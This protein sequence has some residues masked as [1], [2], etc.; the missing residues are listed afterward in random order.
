MNRNLIFSLAL[1]FIT[2]S[3]FSCS[4]EY[5]LDTG[6]F[7]TAKG[8]LHDLSGNC[9]TATILGN[10]YTGVKVTDSNYVQVQVNVTSA[11][12]Y[13][14]ASD[15]ANGFS[16]TNAGTFTTT[17]LQ[18]IKLKAAGTPNLNQN[19]DFI[20]SFDSTI[21]SFTVLVQDST[22]IPGGGGATAS[23]T[24]WQF[25]EGPKYFHGP[26]DTAF[27]FD[28]IVSG[29]KYTTVQVQGG[30]AA[31]RDS[32]LLLAVTF[33]NGVITPGTYPTTS[34]SVFKFFGSSDPT[35][36]LYSATFLTTTVATTVQV[37]AYNSTTRVIQGTF[38]GTAK[39][40]SG[41]SA[42]ITGGK[43]AAKLN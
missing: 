32:V 27:T 37:T 22:G 11:G 10:Y 33:P 21:C 1:I 9:Y 34:F 43:F 6:K 23:D 35:D 40:K 28:T 26:I 12:N 17:G 18:T 25:T 42:T 30:T 20:I 14:I 5:S 15:T 24:A 4:K 38:T 16:F 41:S 7:N 8:S 29:V 31:T 3:F 19:T 13:T 39:T 36:T 2:A